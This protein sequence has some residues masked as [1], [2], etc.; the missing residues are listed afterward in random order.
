MTPYEPCARCTMMRI[1]LFMVVGAFVMGLIYFQPSNA[2]VL[3]SYL[4][5]TVIIA[6]L[7]FLSG[8]IGFGVRYYQMK[9]AR[10]N[11]AK[12]L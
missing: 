7:I 9:T 12:E 8:A 11:G 5:S 4:P 2:V 3:A 10:A 1:K 6:A